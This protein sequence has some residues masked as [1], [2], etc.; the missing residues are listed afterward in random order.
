MT[1]YAYAKSGIDQETVVGKF[2][3]DVCH[4]T[5]EFQHLDNDSSNPF[6]AKS[7]WK[8]AVLYRNVHLEQEN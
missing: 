3:N 2:L 8:T 4:Y 5:L 6:K 7:M 1:L